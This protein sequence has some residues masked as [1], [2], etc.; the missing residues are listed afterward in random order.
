MAVGVQRPAPAAFPP[1]NSRYTLHRR[2]DGPQ[3]RS[4]RVRKISPPTGTRSLDHPARNLSVDRL[5]Y[6][7]PLSEYAVFK[8]S[9]TDS[10]NSAIQG[11]PVALLWKGNYS[12]GLRF[13][14]NENAFKISPYMYF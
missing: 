12:N 10:Q 4:G 1:G 9:A 11:N 6:P 3:G 2:L 8:T 5:C 7:G 13:K 14:A